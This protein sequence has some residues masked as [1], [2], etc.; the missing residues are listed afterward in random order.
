VQ[1]DWNVV[2]SFGIINGL[3]CRGGET[4]RRARLKIW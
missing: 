4:G 2:S 1:I 3:M